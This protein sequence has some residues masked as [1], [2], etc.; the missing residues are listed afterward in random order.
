MTHIFISS[1]LFDHKSMIIDT[2]EP[3]DKLL[4]QATESFL[5]IEKGVLRHACLDIETKSLH[6]IP[7][8]YIVPCADVKLIVEV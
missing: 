3:A 4:S 8:R 5:S 1:E 6:Q 7:A 2:D